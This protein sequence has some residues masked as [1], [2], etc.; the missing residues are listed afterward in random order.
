VKIRSLL[1]VVAALSLL[2][3][4]VGTAHAVFG[5]ADDVPARDVVIPVIC[6][7]DAT[8][9]I[10]TN[11]AIA[12]VLGAGVVDLNGFVAHALAH[13]HNV[14]SKHVHDYSYDWTPN[15]VVVDNCKALTAALSPA[16]K[17]DM[18]V[19][20]SGVDYY[21]GY[22]VVNQNNGPGPVFT[23]VLERFT[24]WVY[25]VDALKGFASG[26]NGLSMEFGTNDAANGGLREA[27]SIGG[28]S[29]AITAFTL[30]PRYFLNNDTALFPDTYNWWMVLLGRNQYNTLNVTST[31]F[32]E[33]F[34]CDEEEN[35]QS[36][37][38]PIPVE[39]NVIDVGPILP[40]LPLHPA[41]FPKGGFA[42]L[43]I[44]EHANGII[45]GA[46]TIHGTRNVS[47]S[48]P[49]AL[50]DWYSVFG[51]SYERAQATSVLAS[52]DVIH[53]MFRTYCN[54]PNIPADPYIT[55]I[56]CVVSVP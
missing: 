12:D 6:G 53:P 34:I 24:A 46:F 18:T 17:T 10:N 19:T 49:L 39:F 42:L 30:Y 14:S 27:F 1:T 38:I 36:T 2:L 37:G 43:N 44:V 32:L 13:L 41:G 51:W 3:F 26:F 35:C 11:W 33:G 16:E 56:P 52:W 25:L 20:I 23:T 48:L 5:V 22:V 55:G 50:T 31:R 45:V 8:N 4:G 7:V 15:D 29:Q 47:T 9:E 21:A 54:V 28:V 40:G